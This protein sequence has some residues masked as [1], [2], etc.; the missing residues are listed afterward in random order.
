MTDKQ[1]QP[2]PDFRGEFRPTPERLREIG[3]KGR[4]QMRD[5]DPAD[6]GEFRE[7][8]DEGSHED[9]HQE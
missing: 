5:L 4:E 7:E 8:P 1:K 9:R 2:Q 6:I 3:E